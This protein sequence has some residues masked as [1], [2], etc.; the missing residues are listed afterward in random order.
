[1]A[2]KKQTKPKI[3]REESVTILA[4]YAHALAEHGDPHAAELESFVRQH[5]VVLQGDSMDP[6]ALTAFKVAAL[7]AWWAEQTNQHA[8]G[9]VILLTAV[10]LFSQW[11]FEQQPAS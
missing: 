11:G 2:F 9:V 8:D 3:S 10:E 4:E 5:A 7:I 6:R 1:M